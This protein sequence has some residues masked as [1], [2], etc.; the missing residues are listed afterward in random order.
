MKISVFGLGYVGVVTSVCFSAEGHEVIGVDVAP[1]KVDL[2]N[3]GISPIVE[4]RIGDLLDECV[5]SGRLRA[6]QSVSEAIA[7]SDL[8]IVCVGTPSGTD[9]SL[10]LGYVSKVI[11][12]IAEVL[13]GREDPFTVVVRST[14]VPGTIENLV[15]PNMRQKLGDAFGEKVKVLFHP[16]FLREGSSVYD[17]YN[18]PK[19]VIGE[20]SPGDSDVLLS[21]Y[22]EKFDAPRIVCEVAVAEMVKYCDNLYHALKVT[23]ANEVGIFAHAHGIDSARV[24]DIFCQDTK[25]NISSKYMRP[26]FA[27]GG[28]CLPK[29]LRAFLAVANQQG[30]SLPMLSSVL[31]SNVG[32]IERVLQLILDNDFSSVGFYGLAFKAGTDDLRESPYVELAERLLGKGKVLSVYDPNVQ[33]ARLTGKNKSVIDQKFPHLASCLVDTAEVLVQND[34]VILCHNAEE[35]FVRDLLEQGKQVVDLTGGFSQSEMSGIT[36]VV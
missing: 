4:E 29:D 31:P 12:E 36:P 21:L 33:I 10:E 23:F 8:C 3:E 22:P 24:M 5:R 27:F 2:L 35:H 25:L 11:S 20:R 6:T 30:L 16:E 18:P 1:K 15:V 14:I 26:G 19:I 34:L 28:S 32:Q 17:F 13:Q 9:G 7:N